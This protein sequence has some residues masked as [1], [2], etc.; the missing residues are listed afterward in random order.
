MNANSAVITKEVID[1]C[2]YFTTV[3]G[4]TSYCAHFMDSVGEW[5]VSSRRLSLGRFNTGGGKYFKNIADSKPFA[6]L[7]ALIS[8]GAI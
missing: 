8:I 4:G 6:A 7:P 1:G 2:A 5:F 3:R